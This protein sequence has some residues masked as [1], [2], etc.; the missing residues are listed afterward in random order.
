MGM[1]YNLEQLKNSGELNQYFYDKI[2]RNIMY[3]EES[4]QESYINDAKAMTEIG[5]SSPDEEK[6]FYYISTYVPDVLDDI[7]GKTIGY[8]AIEIM[9]E[10][11]QNQDKYPIDSLINLYDSV[12]LAAHKAGLPVKAAILQR[13]QMRFGVGNKLAYPQDWRGANVNPAYNIAIWMQATRDIYSRANKGESL[14]EAFNAVTAQWSKMEKIDY[15]HWLKFYQEGAQHKYKIARSISPEEG[16]YYLP[17]SYEDLQARLPNPMMH[18]PNVRLERRDNSDVSN[19]RDRVE[20]QRAR[21]VGRLNAAEKLLSSLDGQMFAGDDQEFML[22][23]LQDLKRKVQTAN[24]ISVRSSLFEDFIFRTGNYLNSIGKQKAA[25]FFFKVAQAP[26]PMELLLDEEPSFSGSGEPNGE[27]KEA[28]REAFREFFSLLETGVVDVDDDELTNDKTASIVVH[29]QA[30]P[31][32]ASAPAAPV[33]RAQVPNENIE[34]ELP[35]TDIA[36]EEQESVE[37]VESAI[38]QALS[39][40]TVSDVVHNLELLSGLFKK[41]EI[42]RRLS[43]VDMMMDKLGISSFFPGLG[44][45]TR[46][47]LESNQYVSTRVEDVLSKL[48]GSLDAEQAEKTFMT[49]ENSSP[50]TAGLRRSLQQEEDLEE[51]R[52]ESRRKR[53][54]AR[55]AGEEQRASETP[56]VPARAPTGAGAGA[57]AAE[58]AQPAAVE[59]TVP[60]PIR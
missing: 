23:L 59:R 37:R 49:E 44:E 43:I 24:K 1:P 51:K 47:A 11:Y 53:E 22:K 21:I 39:T 34:A 48:R 14:E 35:P 28:T 42:A 38:D 19:V 4:Q 7:I 56:P 25:G 10:I 45:A 5:V 40:V 29:A 9:A 16:G 18:E 30:V 32:P 52:R 54:D 12:A 60:T 15:K 26:D 46:S 8:K 41:R 50:E 13:I 27:A 6:T 58:L 3:L 17:V 55:A 20:A 57:G 31:A 2:S 36:T 33:Q